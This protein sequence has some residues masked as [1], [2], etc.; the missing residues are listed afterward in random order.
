MAS[1]RDADPSPLRS[2]LTHTGL[3]LLVFGGIAASLG[4]VI[5]Y[6]GNPANSGPR[7]VLALF[8]TSQGSQANLK[9]RLK[10][11]TPTGVAATVVLADD[12]TIGMQP[13]LGVEYSEAPVLAAE[14]QPTGQGDEDSAGAG[15]RI[16][17]TLVRPGESYGEI[18]RITS[19]DPAPISG[20]SERV[21]GLTL[22]RIS[23]EGRA[24]SDVYARPFANP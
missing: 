18:T 17:G 12:D 19:L 15:I 9:T 22:P 23:A 6:S 24:P 16:N 2:G 10:S 7:E 11:E 8:E 4:A 21:N 3:S 20:L 5:H 1:R 14:A 13:T